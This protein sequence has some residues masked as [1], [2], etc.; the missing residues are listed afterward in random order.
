MAHAAAGVSDAGLHRFPTHLYTLSNDASPAVPSERLI[1]G[2]ALHPREVVTRAGDSPP[3]QT[4]CH[5]TAVLV[6]LYGDALDVDAGRRGVA[7]AERILRVCDRAGLLGHDAR[8]A[9]PG[10]MKVDIADSGL[11]GVALE[12]LDER[13]RGELSP[14]PPS[15][16]VSSPQRGVGL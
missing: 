6:T 14:G 1:V 12:V 9:V 7:V 16:V 5:L 13:V 11:A 8:K 2:V 10:L 15:V 4:V 3:L